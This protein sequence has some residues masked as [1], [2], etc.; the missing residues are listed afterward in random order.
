MLAEVDTAVMRAM[1]APQ[2]VHHRLRHQDRAKEGRA[3]MAEMPA[4]IA[5]AETA[6]EVGTLAPNLGKA[7]TGGA[8]VRERQEVMAARAGS[9]C[10][11]EP[12]GISDSSRC[13]ARA[14][15]TPL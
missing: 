5:Q 7:G 9:G 10:H 6:E 15:R 3:A 2:E 12:T 1:E 11:R 4:P 13:F 14:R 8:G